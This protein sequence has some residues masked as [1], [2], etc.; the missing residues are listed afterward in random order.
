MQFNLLVQLFLK[1]REVPQ[2]HGACQLLN[3]CVPSTQ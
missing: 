1:C 3:H 2:E